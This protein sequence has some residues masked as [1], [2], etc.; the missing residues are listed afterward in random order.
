MVVT[1]GAESVGAGGYSVGAEVPGEDRDTVS[2]FSS[3]SWTV[4][5]KLSAFQQQVFA[6][7]RS[8]PAGHVTTY[9]EVA[10]ATGGCA[11]AVGQC[12]RKNPLAPG[13][14]CLADEEVP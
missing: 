3:S 2:K 11:R 14:G 5:M 8:V 9:G 7:V 4:P 12:M 6:L 10:R 13:S 1:A